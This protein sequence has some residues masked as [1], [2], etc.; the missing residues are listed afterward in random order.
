MLNFNLRSRAFHWQFHVSSLVVIV[1]LSAIGAS[2]LRSCT[3]PEITRDAS[4]PARCP[5]CGSPRVAKLLYGYLADDIPQV[6]RALK[7]G[8]IASGGCGGGGPGDPKWKCG[9]CSF[10]WGGAP[11]SVSPPRPEQ[12]A[13]A[14]DGTCFGIRNDFSGHLSEAQERG[15]P[16]ALRGAFQVESVQI[17]S[18]AELSDRMKSHVR[19]AEETRGNCRFVALWDYRC[20]DFGN[21]TSGMMQVIERYCVSEK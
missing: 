21:G 1:A 20:V 14:D 2:F 15:V 6:E 8:I 5:N 17:V 7:N 19:I 18:A 11:T 13:A 9:S 16:E 12:P 4:W 3:P 10:E